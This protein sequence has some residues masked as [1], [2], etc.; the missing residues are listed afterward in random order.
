METTNYPE[1]M[2]DELVKDIPKEKLQFL[3]SIFT[4]FQ[5]KSQKELMS[6]MMVVMRK[7]KEQN[8]TFNLTEMNS[9]IAAIKKH[10]SPEELEKINN[11][12]SKVKNGGK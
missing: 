4:E 8:L 12:L 3:G 11:I 7:A 6:Q 9:A 2:N 1:W 5:G 10:S